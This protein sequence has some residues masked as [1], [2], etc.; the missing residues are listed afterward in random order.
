[1]QAILDTLK[2][3]TKTVNDTLL[4]PNQ[5]MSKLEESHEHVKKSL[6]KKIFSYWNSKMFPKYQLLMYYS[7]IPTCKNGIL[8]KELYKK[9]HNTYPDTETNQIVD[10]YCYANRPDSYFT[11]DVIE[12]DKT[13]RK[14]F[15]SMVDG[16]L[17]K[18]E[19]LSENVTVREKTIFDD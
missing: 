7:E 17:D 15:E 18:Y 11:L 3:F 4:S 9:F 8:Y 6:P 12:Y 10:D 2:T 14:L 16:L 5:R 19:L 1:M 13:T